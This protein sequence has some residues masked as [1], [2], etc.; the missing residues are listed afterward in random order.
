MNKLI[1]IICVVGCLVFA[2]E[3]LCLA[4]ENPKSLHL[5]DFKQRAVAY[6]KKGY[7]LQRTGNLDG[8]MSFYQKA[9]AFDPYYAAAYNDIGIIYETKGLIDFAEENYLKA[10]EVDKKYLP[11][12]TNLA[13]L[14]EKKADILKAAHYWMM[15]I[16]LGTPGEY[17]TEKAR[18]NF[19]SLSFLSAQVRRIFLKFEAQN[20]SKEVIEKKIREFEEKVIL[21]KEYLKRG[22]EHFN[23]GDYALARESFEQA[24]FLNPNN[25]EVREYYNKAKIRETKKAIDEHTD[26]AMKLYDAG[27][28]DAAREEFNKIL[29]IIPQSNQK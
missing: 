29:T 3:R 22:K 14:Y 27:A 15:R 8:A 17:W 26:R 16:S 18:E 21:S 24:L 9:V 11:A 23:K 20:F 13:F 10:I 7:Q 28:T 1:K 2:M 25:P 5:A 19:R 6:R 12:Y 4:R